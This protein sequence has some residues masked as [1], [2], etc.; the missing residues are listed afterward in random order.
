MP[1]K[2]VHSSHLIWVFS[3]VW[4]VQR[5]CPSDILADGALEAEAWRHI[6]VGIRLPGM[7][8]A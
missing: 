8:S 6:L 2:A 7:T 3:I 1:G 5:S 4:Q